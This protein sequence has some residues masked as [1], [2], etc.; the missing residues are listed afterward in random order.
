MDALTKE[1]AQ[2]VFKDALVHAGI[3]STW[4]WEDAQRVTA[5]DLRIKAL[6]TLAERKA[7]FAAFLDELKAKER[8]EARARRAQQKEAFLQLLD[9]RRGKMNGQSKYYQMARV[10]A[11]DSRFKNVEEKDREEIFQEYVDELLNK[12]IEEKRLEK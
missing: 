10:L 5:S 12:E 4:R 9:E 11:Y 7:A 6:K 1:E 8:N 2:S 3:T